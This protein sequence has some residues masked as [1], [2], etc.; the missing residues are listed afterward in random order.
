[1]ETVWF[2]KW[3]DQSR[4]I[5]P[6][7]N[8][9]FLIIIS[10]SF[11]LSDWIYGAFTFT[12]LILGITGMLMLVTGKFIIKKKQVTWLLAIIIL[13]TGHSLFHFYTNNEFVLRTTLIA[14]VKLGYYL[15]LTV[16]LYNFIRIQ[17]LE[18]DFLYWNN[19]MGVIVCVLA[20][21]IAFAVYAEMNLG[22]AIPYQRLLQFTRVDGH[23]YRRDIPIVRLKSIFEE[24]AH[25]GYYLNALL[26]ANLLNKV[27]V[28]S[29][30]LF[31]S[32]IILTTL[33][34]LSYSAVLIMIA[35]LVF[36]GLQTIRF[37]RTMLKWD[38]KKTLILLGILLVLFLFRDLLYTTLYQRTA[39]LLSG[40]ERSGYERL[41]ISWR[42][43]NEETYLTGLGFMQTPGTLW[44]VFAYIWTELG[45]IYF[46]FYLLFILYLIAMNASIG[47]VFIL[48]N[49]AKGGYLSSSF[50]F[51]ILL[52]LVYSTCNYRNIFSLFRKEEKSENK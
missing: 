13:I 19:V 48:M 29:N 45:I 24:P 52:V 41:V 15:F 40:T 23:L 11:I 5:Q 43:I 17:K 26:L 47:F 16:G 44:N 22:M 2:N 30:G 4:K 8:R 14:V 6:R 12:E 25:L 39:E 10:F 1:L 51:L 3:M 21:Y 28:K 9:F 38:Y 35:I 33:L 20:A 42:F 36:K 31:I 18:S 46:F 37:N 27:K 32:V 34:T 49:I 7:L 50:W